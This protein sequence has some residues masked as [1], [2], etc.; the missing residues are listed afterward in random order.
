[1]FEECFS[2]GTCRLESLFWPAVGFVVFIVILALLALV[3]WIWALVDCFQNEE[4]NRNNK[5]LWI[6]ILLFTFTLGAVLYY[7]MARSSKLKAQGRKAREQSKFKGKRLYRSRT[8]KV[9]GGVCG[10]F[11]EYFDVDPTLIRLFWVLL[12]FVNGVGIL[13]YIIAW[14]IMP[15]K[16]KK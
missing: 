6:I 9:L 1:M 12:I 14:I 15:Q 2:T 5:L 11:A 4:L 7:F 8:D 13:A 16:P 3:M 10:G